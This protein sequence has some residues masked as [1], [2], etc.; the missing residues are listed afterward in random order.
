MLRKFALFGL[1]LAAPAL[2]GQPDTR[3]DLGRLQTGATV[4]FVRAAAG[5]WGL[6]IIQGAAPRI[7]QPKPARLEVFRAEDDI[8]QL[9]AGYKRIRQTGDE[10]D[11]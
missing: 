1:C 9:A 7:T 4:S 3:V 5:E 11:A 8:R 6:E 2:F 10:I